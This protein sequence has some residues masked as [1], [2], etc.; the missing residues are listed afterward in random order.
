MLTPAP[1]AVAA[2]EEGVDRPVSGERDGEDR[3]QRGQGAVE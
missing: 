2:G 1:M 3:G